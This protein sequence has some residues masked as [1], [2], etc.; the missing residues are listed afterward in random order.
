MLSLFVQ[1]SA[2]AGAP[3]EAKARAEELDAVA[4]GIFATNISTLDGS[5]VNSG[6]IT[7]IARIQG[8]PTGTGTAARTAACASGGASGRFEPRSMYG[9]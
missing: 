1:A 6:D 3:A 5:L 7:A 2:S 8:Q 4:Y 9:N